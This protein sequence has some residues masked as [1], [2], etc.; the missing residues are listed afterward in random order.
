MFTF[1]R[2]DNQSVRIVI[3]YMENNVD[4]GSCGTAD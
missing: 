1:I 3:F 2:N 4:V